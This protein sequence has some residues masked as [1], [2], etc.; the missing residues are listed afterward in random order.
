VRL[1]YVPFAFGVICSKPRAKTR[2]YCMEI[3][4]ECFAWRLPD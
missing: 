4:G 1:I 3:F 2:L